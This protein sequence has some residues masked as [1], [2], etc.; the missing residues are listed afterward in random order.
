MEDE[1]TAGAL[2]R[3]ASALRLRMEATNR[4][5][6][7]ALRTSREIIQFSSRS[8]RATHRG[9]HDAARD[10]ALEARARVEALSSSLS[11][12]QSIFHAGFVH[13]AQKE[14]VEAEA[15]RSIALSGPLP[16]PNELA[17]ES[18]AYLNGLAEAASESRRFVLDKL[19]LGDIEEAD[20]VLKVMDDIY[21]ELITFDFPDAIT[22]G[23]R[24]T[25]D[26]LRA[27]LERTRGDL[28]LTYAQRRLEAAIARAEGAAAMPRN[29]LEKP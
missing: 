12:Q 3:I 17:V 11:G 13:D 5:R 6:E 26:A 1:E 20:R 7:E 16:D 2:D 27:V 28:S 21:Y 15:M 22:G 4:H 18:A 9:E 14:Y 23:L 24:R 8:I 29:Y 25:T 19:R 10:L